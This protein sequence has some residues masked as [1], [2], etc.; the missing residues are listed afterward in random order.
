CSAFT[1]DSYAFAMG[2]LEQEGVAVTPGMDFGD[3][4]PEKHLRFA[5]TTDIPNLKEGVRR[6]KR[7]IDSQS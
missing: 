1:D 4:K 3:N 7:F 2:L 5:Y 6:L